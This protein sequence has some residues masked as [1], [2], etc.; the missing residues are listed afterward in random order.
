MRAARYTTFFAWALLASCASQK[1]GRQKVAGRVISISYGGYN[2]P[3]I[4]VLNGDRK[5]ELYDVRSPIIENDSVTIYYTRFGSKQ[6]ADMVDNHSRSR[7]TA[8]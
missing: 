2:T 8:Q 3:S 4:I 5:I 7:R 1:A 6:T